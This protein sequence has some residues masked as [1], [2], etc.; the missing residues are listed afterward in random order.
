MGLSRKEINASKEE[1]KAL[2]DRTTDENLKK[3]Y[4][5]YLYQLDS[6]NNR[7]NDKE[8]LSYSKKLRELERVYRDNRDLFQVIID[9]CN[10][11]SLELDNIKFLNDNNEKIGKKIPDHKYSKKQT[12]ALTRNFYQNLDPKFLSVVDDVLDRKTLSF[13]HFGKDY[14]GINYFIGGINKNYIKLKK[15]GD[16]TDYLTLVHEF[17]HAINN[18][19]N[20]KGYYEFNFFDEFV[21]LFMELVALYEGRNL[22]NKNLIIYEDTDNLVYYFDLANTFNIQHKIVDIMYLNQIN[23]F[24]KTFINEVNKNNNFKKGEIK[25]I[26][27]TDFY[28][29]G[30]YAIG[31]IMALELLYIYKH[32]KKEALELLKELMYKLPLNNQI[33]E[34]SK[35]LEPN[36][37]A[38]GETK[39]II[40]KAK[41]VL[42]KTL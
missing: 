11:L 30:S 42:K 25:D 14:V 26:I 31:Y 34:V 19:F 29:D 5:F 16:Y 18:V 2:I 24:N 38:Y 27:D 17:G 12:I 28:Q 39:E 13:K 41:M 33:S 3:D 7:D 1:L 10:S 22:F 4:L 40:D 15:D 23:K 20:P 21:S 35:Y 36:V 32:N 6:L 8:H 9:Y 37:H